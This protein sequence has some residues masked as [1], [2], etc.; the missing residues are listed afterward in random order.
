MEQLVCPECAQRVTATPKVN[1]LGFPKFQCPACQKVATH[2][3]ATWRLAIY[4]AIAALGVL[5]TIS[6]VLQGGIPIMGIIPALML[7]AVIINFGVAS[8]LNEATKRAQ[9]PP[10]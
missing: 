5:G 3:L 4:I 10:G 1:F 7:A 2:P 6:F 9:G 8:R